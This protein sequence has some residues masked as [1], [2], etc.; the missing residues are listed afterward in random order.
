MIKTNNIEEAK[1][2][3]KKLSEEN[4]K[5]IIISSQNYEFNR[6]IL[7]YGKF[8]ILLLNL[9]DDLNKNLDSISLKSAEKNKVSLALNLNQIR[10]KQ[11]KEKAM[12]IS[13]I[14][15]IISS[16]KKTGANLIF[17]G[18]KDKKDTFSLLISL[19][20]STKQAKEATEQDF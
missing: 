11:K 6:K 7:D 2:H 13:Q 16:C 5:P 9:N 1:R 20:A 3:I 12:I 19:G 4:K 18:N 15:Q 10:T 14:I 8:N 17:L